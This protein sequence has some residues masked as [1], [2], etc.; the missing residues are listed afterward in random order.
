M[1]LLL[2]SLV[3]MLLPRV[4]TAFTTSSDN[5]GCAVVWCLQEFEDFFNPVH[6]VLVGLHLLAVFAEKYSFKNVV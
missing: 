4:R 3:V 5:R 1:F 6:H 2:S